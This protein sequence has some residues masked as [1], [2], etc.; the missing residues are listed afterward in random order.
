MGIA[1]ETI[2]VLPSQ[3]SSIS[4]NFVPWE[5]VL[6][7]K[8]CSSLKSQ[9]FSSPKIYGWLR[10]C[11][12]ILSLILPQQSRQK[13]HLVRNVSE[14]SQ[15]RKI[16]AILGAKYSRETFQVQT[17]IFFVTWCF[18]KQGMLLVVWKSNLLEFS[19]VSTSVHVLTTN[20]FFLFFREGIS[21]IS[22]RHGDAGD[23]VAIPNN[24]KLAIIREKF[25]TF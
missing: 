4:C 18:P 23:A 15:R 6:Q 8:S 7:T 13:C 14:R 5:T 1:V 16:V 20:L 24:E 3:I 22:V 21:I 2:K 9:K 12:G 10:C 17:N 25:P 11:F 19:T